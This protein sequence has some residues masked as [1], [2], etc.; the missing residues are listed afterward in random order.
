MGGWVVWGT[1]LSLVL[2]LWT[3][4]PFYITNV[5]KNIQRFD[6]LLYKRQGLRSLF[7][8]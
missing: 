3:S 5:T 8:F 7:E 6:F 4:H 2:T 1:Y